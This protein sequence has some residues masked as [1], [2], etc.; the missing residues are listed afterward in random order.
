MEFNKEKKTMWFPRYNTQE[1]AAY[2]MSEPMAVDWK[3]EGV[4]SLCSK[5]YYCFGELVGNRACLGIHSCGRNNK[6]NKTKPLNFGAWNVRTLQDR[7]D[8]PERCTALVARLLGRYQIDIAALSE[9]RFAGVTQ[10][11][12]VGGGYTFYYI[13]KPENAPRTSGVEFAIRTKLARQLDS[14]PRGI[15]DR[16]MTLRLRLTIRTALPP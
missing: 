1:N 12:E 4:I 13:G 6:K 7:V 5:K 16:L 3:G 2:T 15:N 8:R 9:T 10:L 14:L 11:K